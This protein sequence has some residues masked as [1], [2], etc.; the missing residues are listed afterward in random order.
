MIFPI[1]VNPST[2]LYLTVLAIW[3]LAHHSLQFGHRVCD[4]DERLLPLGPMMNRN[5]KQFGFECSEAA[6]ED[7]RVY[8]SNGSSV[9]E[10]W[11]EVPLAAVGRKSDRC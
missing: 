4:T 2:G 1:G 9:L 7:G 5:R 6:D 8:D 10:F 11:H 3:G